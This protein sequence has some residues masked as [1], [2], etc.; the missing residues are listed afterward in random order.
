[1]TRQQVYKVAKHEHS[2]PVSQSNGLLALQV[3]TAENVS[4]LSTTLEREGLGDATGMPPSE[5]NF[6]EIAQLH[7]WG[8]TQLIDILI[9]WLLWLAMLHLAMLQLYLI[10]L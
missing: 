9:V 3:L 2:A 8:C 5:C 10:C 4:L 7:S 1:M 6:L